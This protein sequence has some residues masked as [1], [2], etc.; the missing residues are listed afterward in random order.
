VSE[1]LPLTLQTQNITFTFTDFESPPEIHALGGEQLRAVHQFIGGRRVLQTLGPVPH[2]VITWSGIFLGPNAEDRA[3]ALDALRISGVAA[4]LSYSRWSYEGALVKLEL[5][6]GF[7][8]F[9]PYV[10]TFIP[11]VDQ[12]QSGAFNTPPSL[13]NAYQGA[14]SNLTT[15]VNGYAGTNAFILAQNAIIMAQLSLLAQA[16]QLSGGSIEDLSAAAIGPQ[17]SALN[18]ALTALQPTA[19]V[20]F[21]GATLDAVASLETTLAS[22]ED[23]SYQ[24]AAVVELT[25]LLATLQLPTATVVTQTFN[26]PNLLLIAA[27]VYGDASQARL[28]SQANNNFPLVAQGIYT[29]VIPPPP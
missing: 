19:A 24:Q 18:G 12:S 29:L 15:L 4:T 23:L 20:P 3:L 17:V 26:N 6:P 28:I 25:I 14:A 1:Q 21:F 11:T 10:A 2:R 7:Q 16:I 9:L 13:D 22:Q 27:Q 8:G 5:K